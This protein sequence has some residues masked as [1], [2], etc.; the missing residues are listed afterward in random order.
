VNIDLHGDGGRHSD[1]SVE[2]GSKAEDGSR[3]KQSSVDAEPREIHSD[4]FAEIFTVQRQQKQP[5]SNTKLADP[6]YRMAP[7]RK[8]LSQIVNE[9]N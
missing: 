5:N 7:K 1:E 3:N 4:L 9:S 8:S 6:I 2:K